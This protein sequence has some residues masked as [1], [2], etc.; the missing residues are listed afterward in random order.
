MNADT[1][2]AADLREGPIGDSM[3]LFSKTKR[4]RNTLGA[5]VRAIAEE[6]LAARGVERVVSL[7]EP[8]GPEGLGLDSVGRL[9]LLAEVE[10]RCQV[11]IPEAYW[12]SRPLRNLNHLLDVAKG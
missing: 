8:L 6:V 10:K 4:S 7:D 12:G 3:P 11:R 9:D 1:M 2:N 5:E